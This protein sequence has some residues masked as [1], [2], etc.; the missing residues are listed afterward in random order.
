MRHTVTGAGAPL[1]ARLAPYAHGDICGE[2]LTHI[3]HPQ[4]LGLLIDASGQSKR[5]F[6]RMNKASERFP[7]AM[8]AALAERLAQKNDSR[9]QNLL[10][11]LFNSQPEIVTRVTPWLSAQALAVG[12]RPAAA[13]SAH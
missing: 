4:A 1:L 3:N 10:V 5:A 13:K 8:L 9:W 11:V 6:E 12:T 2:A 7:H